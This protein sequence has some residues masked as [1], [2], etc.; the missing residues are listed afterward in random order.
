MTQE[1]LFEK[2]HLQSTT[3]HMV[4]CWTE[5]LHL[6]FL[7]WEWGPVNYCFTLAIFFFAFYLH[8]V[9]IIEHLFSLFPQSAL[10][11]LTPT[12]G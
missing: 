1:L 10:V 8:S 4:Y 7:D 2:D 9:H 5:V 11:M 12:A 6:I 3:S